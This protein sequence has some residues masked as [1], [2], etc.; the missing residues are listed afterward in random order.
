MKL[1]IV[2]VHGVSRLGQFE[3]GEGATET[4]NDYCSPNDCAGD[5]EHEKSPLDRN[6]IR[7]VGAMVHRSTWCGMWN[8]DCVLGGST[9]HSG[10][11]TRHVAR[12]HIASSSVAPMLIIANGRR[13]VD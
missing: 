10:A 8:A 2:L 1:E 3:E 6:Q 4:R 9:S 11:H 5:M 7:R 12:R 13:S